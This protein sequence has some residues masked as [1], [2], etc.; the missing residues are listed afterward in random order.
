MEPLFWILGTGFLMCIFSLV[1][2]ITFL[3]KEKTVQKMTLPMVAF[4]AGSLMGGAFFHMLPE[5][6]EKKHADL[7]NVFFW[8]IVGFCLFFMIEQFLHW[9]H[10]HRENTD[11]GGGT[12]PVGY[13]FLFGDAL[14]N[15]IDGFTVGAAFL[16]NIPLGLTTWLACV[17]HEIPQELG[18]FGVLIHSGWSRKKALFFNF[19]SAL[20][21]PLGGVLTYFVAAYLS[22]DFLIPLAAGSFIYIA[23]SDLVPEINKHHSLKVNFLHFFAFLAGILLL[24]VI[25]GFF[26][27][28][29]HVH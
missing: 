8:V 18:D 16:T 10:C 5:A 22:V 1:G 19:L 6:I 9:H 14:H 25:H 11:C 23:A 17:A 29:T 20:T 4:A 26:H 12:E 3:L 28:H 7:H 15:L 13:L 24:Y 2:G 27:V 21:F